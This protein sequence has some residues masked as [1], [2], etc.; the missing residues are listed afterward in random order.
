M[1]DKDITIY[2]KTYDS[3]TRMDKY[4][5]NYV[6][7][8]FYDDIDGIAIGRYGAKSENKVQVIIPDTSVNVKKEDLIVKGITNYDF[9]T[10]A[11]LKSKYNVYLVT[12]AN[13]KD[14][15]GLQNIEVGAK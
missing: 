10:L 2:N 15:G 14:F 4:I 11:D 12:S 13:V 9:A 5:A 1:F 7:N 8:V 3:A 6:H